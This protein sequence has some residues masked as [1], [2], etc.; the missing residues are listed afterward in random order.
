MLINSLKRRQV[1]LYEAEEVLCQTAGKAEDLWCFAIE[2]LRNT[3]H[4]QSILRDG[5]FVLNL[6]VR[7]C[8][9]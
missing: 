3:S 4:Q 6:G 9:Y 1:E 7:Q 8:S 2:A 5:E